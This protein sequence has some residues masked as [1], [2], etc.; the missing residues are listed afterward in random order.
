MSIL[1]FIS[2]QIVLLLN[3]I[4]G[5]VKNIL[6][7]IAGFADGAIFTGFLYVDFVDFT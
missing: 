1:R 4:Y 7:S 3:V 5:L 6:S 2:S